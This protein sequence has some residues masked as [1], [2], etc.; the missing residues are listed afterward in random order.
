LDAHID[1]VSFR[2]RIPKHCPAKVCAG[3][4][5]IDDGYVHGAE[6]KLMP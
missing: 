6:R 5:N 3:L 4:A 2:R 1:V